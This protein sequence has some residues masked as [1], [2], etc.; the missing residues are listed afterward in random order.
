MPSEF[1]YEASCVAFS[2]WLQLLGKPKEELPLQLAL[3]LPPDGG[4][5]SAKVDQFQYWSAI[6]FK[7]AACEIKGDT[8]PHG[9][10]R[11]VA[12]HAYVEG[13]N[14]F[15]QIAIDELHLHLIASYPPSGKLPVFSTG[16]SYIKGLRIRG[17]P[18]EVELENRLGDP[19][20]PTFSTFVKQIH[21]QRP[22]VRVDSNVI[23]I[24]GFGKLILAR[25]MR[26]G[27]VLGG[28]LFSV[29]IE[30]GDIRGTLALC[31]GTVGDSA[32]SSEADVPE[33]REMGEEEFEDVLRAL[34]AWASSHPTPDEPFLYMT[35]KVVTPKELLVDVRRKTRLGVAFLNSLTEL[36]RQDKVRPVQAIRWSIDANQP[37]PE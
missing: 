34:T 32:Q 6:S 8:V 28:S 25:V 7:Y 30:F 17:T 15:D 24:Q 27:N 22:D 10:A 14:L 1:N 35:G 29:E 12:L 23:S 2:G 3:G 36:A 16:D 11:T 18:C 33:V 19:L 31:V 4:F 5:E 20:P 37:E 9:E 26:T 13:C 21:I